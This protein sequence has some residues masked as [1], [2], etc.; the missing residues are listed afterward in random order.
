MELLLLELI[1]RHQIPLIDQETKYTFILLNQLKSKPKNQLK[2]SLKKIVT[3]KSVL[4]GTSKNIPRL[5]RMKIIQ[6]KKNQ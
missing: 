4:N 2:W 5:Q 3:S 6:S 1:L